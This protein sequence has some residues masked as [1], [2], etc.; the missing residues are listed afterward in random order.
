V[1]VEAGQSI[2][3]AINFA[4]TG[5]TIL[6][7][8]GTH[9]I[10]AQISINKSIV[11]NGESEVG[12]TINASANGTG[13]GIQVKADN[14]TLGNF[15]IIPPVTGTYGSSSGGGYPIHASFNSTVPK[16]KYNNLAINNITINASNRTGIDIHGYNGVAVSNVTITNAAYGNGISLTGCSNVTVNGVTTSGNAW[17]GI[18]VYCSNGTSYLGVGSDNVNIDLA[19]N[20][21]GEFV[22]VEDEFGLTNTNITIGN[23]TYGINNKYSGT[24]N[25]T[26][27][28]TGT[29]NDAFSF[30]SLLNTK[31]A[32]SLSAV[33]NP[34]YSYFVNDNFK[35]QS[36][37]SAA[38]SGN[39]INVL[40]GTYIENITINK[41]LTITGADNTTTIIDGSDNGIVV[42]VTS[43]NVNLSGFTVRNSG[44][45]GVEAGV[46]LSG[47]NGCNISNN[48]ISDN[49]AGV[50]LVASTSNTI[51]NNIL[52]ANYF[53]V[54]L[55]N[56]TTP[57][58]GNTISGNTITG[59]IAVVLAPTLNTGDGI[60]ADQNCN[61]N[62][63]LNN[64]IQNNGKDGIYFWKS[65]SNTV[66]GNTI[67][68]NTS[69]GIQ[70]MGSANNIFTGNSVVNN[71]DNG[72]KIRSSGWPE[73]AYPSFPNTIN[74]NNIHDN[75]NYDVI[76]EAEV[77]NVN[78]EGNWWGS[79]S[80]DFAN[81]VSGNVDYSPWLGQQSDDPHDPDNP[82]VWYVD[83][84]TDVTQV[85]N[86]AN[87]ED[88]VIFVNG[89]YDHLTINKPITLIGN[90]SV[91]SNASPAITVTVDNVTITGF[92]FVFNDDTLP[93]D[94]Y[95]IDVQNNATNIVIN[96]CNFQNLLNGA[97]G[98][99]VI[100]RGTG[101]VD[102]RYNYWNA[103]SGPT[104]ASNPLGTGTIA[105]NISSGTLLYFPWYIDAGRTTLMTGGVTLVSPANYSVG[106]SVLLSLHG[107]QSA[108]LFLLILKYLPTEVRGQQ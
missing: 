23:Y 68:G 70:L 61:N 77:D 5:D 22:Y 59:S 34:G 62:T 73:G 56:T 13:Y 67:S 105:S 40:A 50:A 101:T 47:A 96:Q 66:T 104:I 44:L 93:F 27:F 28:I 82:W 102:A 84:E 49:F 85:I 72:F 24:A 8:N 65:S 54:Y 14:V 55:G 4:N 15:T 90:G 106:V 81:I 76:A 97:T 37:I 87:D 103:A 9:T 29:L 92:V 53:G 94:D 33:F 21:I 17:G 7:L 69:Q 78:A 38:S 11:L 18:A 80:P 79:T 10:T 52:S 64:I 20:N 46:A 51:S 16:S 100:N 74:E 45:T 98:N 91:I 58:T 83:D 89:I 2:Q 107:Q 35:I 63:Y 25:Y 42:N 6:L 60:Y 99:G 3:S 31:F 43:N 48:I 30:A 26:G 12:T 36:A 41:P 32:N 108:M 1:L 88:I 75:S 86:N 19:A 39:T 71:N 57:S 95:A